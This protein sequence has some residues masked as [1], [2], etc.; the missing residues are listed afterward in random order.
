MSRTVDRVSLYPSWTRRTSFVAICIMGG[1]LFLPGALFL[2]FLYTSHLV[3]L[4]KSRAGLTH[5]THCL[6]AYKLALRWTIPFM[7]TYNVRSYWR[8]IYYK[9]HSIFKVI[10]MCDLHYTVRAFYGRYTC[11]YTPT[12]LSAIIR[13]LFKFV[14]QN[15]DAVP[16]FS[17]LFRFRYRKKSRRQWTKKAV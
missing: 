17:L 5:T 3:F 16:D 8:L 9:L 15:A 14:T 10:C 6:C 11:A 12:T 1:L 2:G 13:F 7:F 4:R